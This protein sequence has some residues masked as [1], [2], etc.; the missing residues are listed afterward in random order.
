LKKSGLIGAAGYV[1]PRHMQAIK[2]SGNSLV[3]ALDKSDSVGISDSYF[4]SADYVT[5]FE[6]FDR[7]VELLSRKNHPIDYISICSP[8]YLHDSHIRFS[9]L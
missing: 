9:M 4:P 2:E 3:A 7:H 6:R 8:N 5:Q 1:A